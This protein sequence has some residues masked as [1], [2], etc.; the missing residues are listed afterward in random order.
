MELSFGCVRSFDERGFESVRYQEAFQEQLEV[1][2]S[3]ILR[4]DILYRQDKRFKGRA[5]AGE[6]S[7][8]QT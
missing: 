3:D 4:S 5:R 7:M 8:G 1:L 2:L 6:P